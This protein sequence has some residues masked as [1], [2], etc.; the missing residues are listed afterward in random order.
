MINYKMKK[1][2]IV[3][4]SNNYYRNWIDPIFFIEIVDVRGEIIEF[5]Y[6]ITITSKQNVKIN[7]KCMH[8]SYFK[9]DIQKTRK[10]KIKQIYERI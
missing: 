9:Y 1:G 10:K 6:E 4:Q 8:I 2:D 3:T 5:K 7:A